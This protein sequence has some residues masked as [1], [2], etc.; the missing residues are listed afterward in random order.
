MASAQDPA[1]TQHLPSHT[2]DGSS[3]PS[4][5]LNGAV[6]K[7]EERKEQE[8]ITPDPS[9]AQPET[10]AVTGWKWI[11]VCVGLYCAI[12]LYGL[13]NTIAADIQ[14]AILETYG[15]VGQLAWI[16]TGF[17]LGSVATILPV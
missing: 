5:S 2:S 17:P 10:R 7:E 11:M 12:F 4:K 16:G 13:D 15:E 9:D 1:T 8:Q 14:S 3:D 6:E